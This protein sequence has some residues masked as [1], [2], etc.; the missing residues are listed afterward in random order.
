LIVIDKDLTVELLGVGINRELAMKIACLQRH[1]LFADWSELAIE[2][3]A[4]H[5]EITKVI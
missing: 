3:L 1:G 4:K 5:C 2:T